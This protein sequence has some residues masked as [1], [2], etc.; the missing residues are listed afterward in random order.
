MQEVIQHFLFGFPASVLPSSTHQGCLHLRPDNG[1]CLNRRHF[2]GARAIAKEAYIY[3]EPI[4]GSCPNA[5]CRTL[6]LDGLDRR[7]RQRSLAG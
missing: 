1:T 7:V 3:G 6:L 2:G 5:W 4:L